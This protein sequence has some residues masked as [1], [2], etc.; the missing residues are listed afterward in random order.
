MNILNKTSENGKLKAKLSI[1]D[2]NY[3]AIKN[4]KG[5]YVEVDINDNDLTAF[6]ALDFAFSKVKLASKK[7]ECGFVEFLVDFDST[8]TN[9]PSPSQNTKSLKVYL[10]V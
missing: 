8:R 5:V 4:E 1:E 10:K 9:N 2:I 3:T 6:S 7:Q